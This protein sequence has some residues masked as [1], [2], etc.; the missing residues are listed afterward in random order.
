MEDVVW[1]K[2]TSS[3]NK[4][5]IRDGLMTAQHYSD[6]LS[7]KLKKSNTLRRAK[8]ADFGIAPFGKKA[9]KNKNNV[10]KFTNHVEE[11]NVITKIMNL[12]KKHH[13]MYQLP[14]SDTYRKIKTEL[15]KNSRTRTKRGKE[16]TSHM[17]SHI[18]KQTLNEQR[19]LSNLN[20]NSLD[21]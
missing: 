1:N 15:K 12:Y 16:W 4:K 19:N 13:L 5:N 14:K 7:E 9:G 20:M 18:I 3:F 21:L 6:Q 2:H 17:I 8:G 11:K 10:R